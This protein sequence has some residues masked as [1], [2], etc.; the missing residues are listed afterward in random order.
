MD[1]GQHVDDMAEKLNL[2]RPG[3]S[4]GSREVEDAW[5]ATSSK[6]VNRVVRPSSRSEGY[7]KERGFLEIEDR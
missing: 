7:R 6:N 2:R 3:K 4:I 5:W 1:H